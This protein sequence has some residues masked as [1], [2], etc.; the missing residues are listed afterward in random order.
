MKTLP[1][2]LQVKNLCSSPREERLLQFE[3]KQPMKE[4][5]SAKEKGSSRAVRTDPVD[6]V[7]GLKV[8]EPV[9]PDDYNYKDY[10]K[11]LDALI[12]A[13]KQNPALVGEQEGTDPRELG[14]QEENQ[15]ASGCYKRDQ[16][17]QG[18]EMAGAADAA[19]EYAAG[20]AAGIAQVVVG[21]PFDTVKVSCSLLL[22]FILH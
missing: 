13:R 9:Y 22:I 17:A 6:V 8:H 12:E 2:P 14:E 15:E 16:Q 21:H 20:C 3:D 4:K 7:E 5:K 1:P 11:D 18:C 19:K 10:K